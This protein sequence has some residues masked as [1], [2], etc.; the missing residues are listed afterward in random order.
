MSF[1][2]A[3]AFLAIPPEELAR[4]V[5][6]G[7]IQ[8]TVAKR[9]PNPNYVLRM[10]IR[11]SGEDLRAFQRARWNSEQD[12]AADAVINRA[13]LKFGKHPTRTSPGVRGKARPK[14]K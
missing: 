3:S 2:D 6:S 11:L 5:L 10:D 12:A 8:F 7:F 1:D 14:E 4:L 9:S 13:A